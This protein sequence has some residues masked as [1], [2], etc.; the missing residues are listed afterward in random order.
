MR[1]N[2]H[3]QKGFT[4]IEVIV[5]LILVGILGALAGLGIVS[6]VQGYMFSK[7]NAAISEKAQLAIARINREL[8][9]CYENCTGP[10]DADVT[11][12][13]YNTLGSRYIKMSGTNV[14]INSD[15]GATADILLDKVKAG[16]FT[17]TYEADKSILVVFIIVHQGGT[18]LP[19]FISRVYPRNT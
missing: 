16:S 13:I 2:F 4:L 7:E 8:L 9:E 11:F 10:E 12:P 5:V 19:P 6:A 14:I 3:R 15:N 17:M 1:K 18:E